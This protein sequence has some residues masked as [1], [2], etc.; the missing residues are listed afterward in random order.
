MMTEERIELDTTEAQGE[1]K[2][3]VNQQFVNWLNEKMDEANRSVRYVARQLGVAHVTLRS[4]ILGDNAPGT[5]GVRKLAQFFKVDEDWL[6]VLAGHR[7][8]RPGISDP[9]R[10]EFVMWLSSNVDKISRRDMRAVRRM[11]EEL[12][13]TE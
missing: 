1:V 11:L 4:W 5:D 7:S 10:E 3:L 13:K 12:L 2:P 8:A 9:E 6:L